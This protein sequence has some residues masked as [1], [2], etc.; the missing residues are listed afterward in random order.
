MAKRKN[1]EIKT[2]ALLES[3]LEENNFWLVDVEYVKEADNY[4]LRVYADKEGGINVND[5]ELI[6]RALEAKLDEEDFVSDAYT[7]EVSSPGLDRPLKKPRDFEL[8]IGKDV[9]LKLYKAVSGNKEFVGK[10]I[11]YNK[12]SVTIDSDGINTVF[13]LKDVSII[14]L[15]IIF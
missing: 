2:M 10:L 9:E 3:I 1:I 4:F 5:L 13:E 6:S 8:S 11:E 12:D 14:R 15:A 7:L